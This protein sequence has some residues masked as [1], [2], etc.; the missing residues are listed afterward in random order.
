MLYNDRIIRDGLW[1]WI[2]GALATIGITKE[3]ECKMG[4]IIMFEFIKKNGYIQE[5]EP[6]AVI[7]TIDN[8]FTLFSPV[9][10]YIIKTNNMLENNPSLIN[11]YAEDIELLVVDTKGL[12]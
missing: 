6:F 12:I 7:E 3:S 8:E 11:I 9:S 4:D 1:M 5:G 10:G 2:D